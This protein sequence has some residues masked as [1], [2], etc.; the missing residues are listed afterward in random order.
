MQT[1]T[2]LKLQGIVS[3]L[4]LFT[5]LT[6]LF[7]L[8]ATAVDA[9]REHTQSAWPAADATVQ[10]CSIEPYRPLRSGGRAVVWRIEC[11]IRY[12]A[13]S[14]QVSARIRSRSVSS[15][16]S[17][18]QQM[19][20]WVAHHRAGSSIAIHFDPAHHQTAVLTATDMP[21]AG[22]RTPDDLKLLLISAAL[23]AIFVTLA[24]HMRANSP[25]PK[26]QPSP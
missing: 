6:T 3:L 25:E 15:W 5:V 2:P 17:S 26:S 10:R 22:P 21:F 23:C 12:V 9:W 7:A 1:K 18:T 11:S 14:E 16:S 4:A 19:S 24:R 13:D 8:V 20:D